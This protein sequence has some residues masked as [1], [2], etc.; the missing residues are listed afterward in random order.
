MAFVVHSVRS[1]PII[2]TAAL[3]DLPEE[4]YDTPKPRKR[5]RKFK[6]KKYTKRVNR[7]WERG[8]TAVFNAVPKGAM[9]PAWAM[10]WLQAVRR[11]DYIN[12]LNAQ[13]REN[14]YKLALVMARSVDGTSMTI[15]PGW[16]YLIKESG[17]S[18][19]TVNRVRQRLHDAGLMGT[20][21]KGRTAA[22]TPQRTINERAVYVICIPSPLKAV[23]K[24]EPPTANFEEIPPRTRDARAN[25]PQ[26]QKDVATPRRILEAL[27]EGQCSSL[28]PAKRKLPEWSSSATPKS[29]ET[30]GERREAERQVAEMLQARFFALRGTTTADVATRCREFFVAGYTAGDIAWALD[31]FADGSPW[32]NHDGAHG[33]KDVGRW[34]KYRLG[35]HKVDGT[36]IPSKSQRALA[37]QVE[38]KAQRRA[39][40]EERAVRLQ[41]LQ[42]QA[43]VNK[44]GAARARAVV[45]GYAKINTE[46]GEV[47]INGR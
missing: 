9:R 25:L 36:V 35:F 6:A 30:K 38:L 4:A 31:H 26:P 12:A 13:A 11:S 14:V 32:K 10:D 33:V 8:H 34:M 27:P 21:A 47:T 39:A 5:R 23:E 3:F 22:W 20:V 45:R 40:L 18:R 43:E 19:S 7:D 2:H 28:L 24:S 37:R 44:V 17:L 46:T 1:D 41:Q 16:E 29:A 42:D 15:R